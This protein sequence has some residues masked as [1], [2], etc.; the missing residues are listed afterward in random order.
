MLIPRIGLW[1]VNAIRLTRQ[2][3]YAVRCVLELA[4]NYGKRL[5]TKDVAIR[6]EIPAMFLTKILGRLISS[7]L[8]TSQRGPGGG[9]M[10]AKPPDAITLREVIESIEGPFALNECLGEAGQCGRKEHCK[11][12]QVWWRAQ[13]ALLREL[14]VTL[15]RL[16]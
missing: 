11:V 7:G 1:G 14:D 3:E 10:L 5:S 13:Q 6:Q 4:R 9:I 15:D 16:I 2:G 8:V 12:H